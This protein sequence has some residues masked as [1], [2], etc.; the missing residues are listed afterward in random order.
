MIL[1]ITNKEDGHPNPVID[2]WREWGVPFFR[3]NTE[4]LLTDYEFWW[5]ADNNGCDF[6]IR[7]RQ[8]GLEVLGSEV[9]AVWERRP[10]L[11]QP[12]VSST[13]EIDKH[14]RAEA[15]GFLQFLRFYLKDIPSIG[16]I[17]NDRVAASKMLQQREALKCGFSIPETMFS[18]R[19]E[20]ILGFAKGRSQLALK[21]IDNDNVYDAAHEADYVFYTQTIETGQLDTVPDEAFSQTVSFVQ[22]YIPKAYELR[23]T[24]VG[25]EVFATKID[26]Q[27]GD[28][29]RGKIDW[30]EV[31]AEKQ[32]LSACDISYK[33]Q[34][35]CRRLVKR[36][37][38][39]FGCIDLI[40]TPEEKAIFLECN[41]NGQWLWVEL[42]TGQQISKSIASWLC[43][44]NH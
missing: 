19:K 35:Q 12:F 33:L 29:L 3:L 10:E 41:P 5:K 11:P 32:K 1:L 8:N 6:F 37:G 16:S 36:L 44:N 17:V 18:N 39:N 30:R 14:N 42:L 22:D 20:S 4:A 38:L 25:E 24:V 40:V 9:T 28:N 23:I 34:T 31:D 15:L 2:W 26:S 13:P 21:S 7:C 43:Q 27:V